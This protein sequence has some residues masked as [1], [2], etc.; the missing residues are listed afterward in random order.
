M[1]VKCFAHQAKAYLIFNPHT[2]PLVFFMT[3]QQTAV[4]FYDWLASLQKASTLPS[5]P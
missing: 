2:D 1:L 3:C 5:I 4:L